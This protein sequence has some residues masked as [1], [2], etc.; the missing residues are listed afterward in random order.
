MKGYT[1]ILR[2]ICCNFNYGS[3]V[4]LNSHPCFP[5]FLITAISFL[6]FEALTEVLMGS[7]ISNHTLTGNVICLNH[8]CINMILLA[9]I[10]TSFTITL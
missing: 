6:V 10:M 8:V 1:F 7:F 3:C 2:V 9:G 5:H 4:T